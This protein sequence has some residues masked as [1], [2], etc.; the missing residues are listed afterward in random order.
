MQSYNKQKDVNQ[1]VVIIIIS[2][3]LPS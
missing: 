1:V 3:Q 2:F